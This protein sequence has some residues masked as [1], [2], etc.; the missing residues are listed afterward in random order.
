[1]SR[2]VG[3]GVSEKAVPWPCTRAWC[4]PAMGEMCGAMPPRRSCSACCSDV[5]SSYRVLPPS[6]AAMNGASGFKARFTCRSTPGRPPP[7]LPYRCELKGRKTHTSGRAAG[8]PGRSF[9]QWR[10][11]LLTAPSTESSAIGSISSSAWTRIDGTVVHAPQTVSACGELPPDRRK[12]QV[13]V[14]TDQ[15]PGRPSRAP[16]CPLF[17]RTTGRDVLFSAT[18]GLGFLVVDPAH[19]RARSG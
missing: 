13:F 9:T 1:M 18:H 10:L 5:R 8:A 6:I 14:R 15:G 3:A 2:T 16:A 19:Q 7:I 11:M 17:K 12:R 4:A